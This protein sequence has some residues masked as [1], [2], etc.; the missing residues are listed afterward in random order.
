MITILHKFIFAC[1]AVR[2]S[3]PRLAR[4]PRHD[5]PTMLIFLDRDA[6]DIDSGSSEVAMPQSVLRLGHR[7]RIFGDHA[8]KRVSGLVN[9]HAV[10]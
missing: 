4:E 5:F 7:T 1:Y 10:L 6:I 3:P 2:Y 8:C 9:M